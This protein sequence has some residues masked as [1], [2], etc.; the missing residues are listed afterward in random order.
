[1]KRSTSTRPS[2]AGPGRARPGPGPQ[3]SPGA[4]R[5][6]RGE[7]PRH[8]SPRPSRHADAADL[9]GQR[10]AAVGEHAR[11]YRFAELLEIG[12]RR[13][14][15]VDQEVAV[16]LRYHCAALLQAATAGA[17]DQL[18]GLVAGWVGEGAA[19]GPRAD[20]LAGFAA[21]LDIGHAA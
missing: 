3:G 2:C 21:G 15:G 6:G 12:G 20:R 5:K 8:A 11:P 13:A 18:P 9:P 4:G 17:V 19:A 1:M 14:A 7:G 16:L 10:D